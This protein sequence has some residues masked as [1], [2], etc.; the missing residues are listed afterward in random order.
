MKTNTEKKWDIYNSVGHDCP[1]LIEIIRFAY[2]CVFPFTLENGD[3]MP[4]PITPQE[5]TSYLLAF[6][7]FVH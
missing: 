3:V 5:F 2:L 4:K 6:C 7:K 1:E